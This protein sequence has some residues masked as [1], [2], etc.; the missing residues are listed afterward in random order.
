MLSIKKQYKSLLLL[1]L[2]VSMTLNLKG[3]DDSLRN[4]S[5]TIQDKVGDAKKIDYNP[6]IDPPKLNPPTLTYNI[7]GKEYKTKPEIVPSKPQNYNNKD[8][9]R[10]YG[11]YTKIGYGMYNMPLFETYF[12][13][14]RS[15]NY[16]YGIRYHFL[17]GEYLK[18]NQG[19]FISSIYRN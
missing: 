2:T 15:K 8:N 19:R 18:A 6:Q 4:I 14:T 1:V 9:E 11:N 7:E 17:S 5:T 3:Q 10:M 16:D 12:H 13:N